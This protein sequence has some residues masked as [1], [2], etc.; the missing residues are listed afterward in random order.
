MKKVTGVMLALAGAS[1][2]ASAFANVPLNPDGSPVAGQSVAQYLQLKKECPECV[3]VAQDIVKMRMQHCKQN[4][5]VDSII[6]QD[7]VYSYLNSI[8]FLVSNN[9]GYTNFV[10]TS[11]RQVVESNVNCNDAN[12][13]IQRSQKVM[14]KMFNTGN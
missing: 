6:L 11:A 10:Y 3:M 9:G 1:F 2:C 4:T 7:P 13:W 8:R 14:E 5:T 12:D